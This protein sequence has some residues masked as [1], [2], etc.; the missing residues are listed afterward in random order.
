MAEEESQGA[1]IVPSLDVDDLLIGFLYAWMKDGN[2]EARTAIFRYCEYIRFH[3]YPD[4]VFTVVD[5]LKFMDM[6]SAEKW[7][8]QTHAQYNQNDRAMLAHI[9]GV[10]NVS[11]LDTE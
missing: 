2:P 10:K 4:F 11:N 9:F 8:R 1:G 6:G 3:G 5:S 7:I